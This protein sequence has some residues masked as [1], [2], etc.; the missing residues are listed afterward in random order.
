MSFPTDCIALMKA[1]EGLET[2]TL[3]DARERDPEG[4]FDRS[5][6]ATLHHRGYI[7]RAHSGIPRDEHGRCIWR[8]KKPIKGVRRCS[9]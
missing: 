3:A 7:E 5:T 2:F 8:V 9:T 4:N 6:I 1:V